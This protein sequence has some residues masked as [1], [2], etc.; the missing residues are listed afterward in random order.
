MNL[1]LGCG[2]RRLEG[3]THIDSRPEVHP[4]I[5]ADVTDLAHLPDGCAGIVYAC[6]VLEHVARPE[7]PMVLEEWRRVL[8]PGGILRLSVPDFAVLARLYVEQ[9][10]SLWRLIG[11]LMGRQ[12]RAWNTHRSA[13]DYEYLAWEMTLAGYIHVWRWEPDEVLPDGYDDY[14]RATINGVAISLNVEGVAL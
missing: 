12:D 13:Y 6:H 11:P 9:G 10:V 7:V 5:V 4:D 1:H 2:H 14:S 8:R 3:Y